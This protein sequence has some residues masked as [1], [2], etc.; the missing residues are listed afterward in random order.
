LEGI[1]RRR[2]RQNWGLLFHRRTWFNRPGEYRIT[3]GRR[4]YQSTAY[5]A[6]GY[7][8]IAESKPTR[9]KFLSPDL[10]PQSCW[11]PH[12]LAI[13]LCDDISLQFYREI[14]G[15]RRGTGGKGGIAPFP[16]QVPAS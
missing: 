15:I 1:F 14:A 11:L 12:S 4:F 16:P 3:P 5:F 8:D 13:D 6:S 7:E 10:S 2:I 9:L